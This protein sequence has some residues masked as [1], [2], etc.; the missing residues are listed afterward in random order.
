MNGEPHQVKLYNLPRTEKGIKIYGLKDTDDKEII[1]LFYHIDGMYSYCK[2]EGTDKV[3]HLP[4][5][6]QLIEMGNDEYKVLD[7]EP[8]AEKSY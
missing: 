2:I 4:A 3:V 8:E 5:T 1:V 6:L 7:E